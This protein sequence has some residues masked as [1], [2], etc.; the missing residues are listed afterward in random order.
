MWPFCIPVSQW[1]Q[2]DS[3]SGGL[4][5]GRALPCAYKHV[6]VSTMLLVVPGRP[7]DARG[8]VGG[9]GTGGPATRRPTQEEGRQCWEVG[10]SSRASLAKEPAWGLQAWKCIFRRLLE[11]KVSAAG[12]VPSEVPCEGRSALGLAP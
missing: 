2:K 1:W 7:G 9:P 3:S 10:E 4:A 8:Q 12:S 5:P 6:V 11:D